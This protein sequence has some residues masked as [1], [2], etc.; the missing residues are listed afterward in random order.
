NRL[1][2]DEE[3][4]GAVRMALRRAGTIA[5]AIQDVRVAQGAVCVS[6]LGGDE[7]ARARG[8]IER[9][10]R[11]VDGVRATSVVTAA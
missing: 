10:C 2:S 6:L 8:E 4:L 3:L 5:D 1:Y 9:V 7:A 11:A